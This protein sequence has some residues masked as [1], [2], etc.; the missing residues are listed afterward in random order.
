[1][2]ILRKEAE[3]RAQRTEKTEVDFQERRSSFRIQQK[4]ILQQKRLSIQSEL[5]VN[6][7]DYSSQVNDTPKIAQLIEIDYKW[8]G[9]RARA[10][11]DD[12]I[13]PRWVPDEEIMYCH[14]CNGEFD[15]VN[16]KHHCRHCGMVYCNTCSNNKLLL[17]HVFGYRDPVRVCND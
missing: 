16:R 5:Q 10:H 14:G 11:N 12:F 6:E 2:D 13:I 1:M 4:Q 15:Y 9:A 3:E 7:D 17:P 8:N